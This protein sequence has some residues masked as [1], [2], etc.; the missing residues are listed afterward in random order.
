[1]SVTRTLLRGV[2]SVWSV[3]CVAGLST[4][5]EP[6]WKAGT[7][8]AVITPKKALWMAGYG[9]RTEPAEG[10]LHDLWIRVLALEDAEGQRGIVLSSDTLGIPKA[11]YDEV[12]LQVQDRYQL[13]RSQVMLHA[14]HT[15]CGPVI[16][17]A[18]LDIYPVNEQ[19]LGDI[20]D[21][22]KWLTAEI[23]STIGEA[24]KD[25]Q[26]VTISRG[27]GSADFAVNRRTN[28]EPD[29]PTL[30][31]Q[32]LLMGPVDHTVPVLA[33]YGM[34]DKLKAVVFT[35]ACHNTTLSFQKW[36]GD[37]AG[38]AQYELE[39]KHP[40]ATALFCMG[41]GADQNPLPRRTIE[42][43]E[44]YGKKL[45]TAVESV[46]SAPRFA[47]RP[48][49]ESRHAFVKLKMDPFPEVSKLE[50]MAAEPVSYTQRWASR[51]LKL[52]QKGV[53]TSQE[54]DYP[55]LVWR[56]GGDQLWITLGGEV[57]VDYA[58]RLKGEFGD[59]TWVSAYTNDVMAYIPS[60][61]VLLEGGYEGQSS[62]MVYGMPTER[63]APTVEERIDQGVA[64]LVKSL[65]SLP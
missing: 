27:I 63:W 22:F 48:K 58:L 31:E 52:A 49:L 6:G 47:V 41:C 12:C 51:L 11:M 26:P 36:C 25:L 45:A 50:K 28:R 21:Y 15:H 5:A 54:Y 42:L 53:P 34:D 32:N 65:P 43:C 60:K 37:Y 39:S 13:D 1:M 59:Q 2:V 33:V 16:G 7:A 30:R 55:I 56:L 38:F 20:H 61:R 14:S 35:Y 9:S 23:V 8:R 24:L 64:I 10:K 19:Q 57:V 62:M 44:Q 17:T 3:V 4:A 46:L 29:V 18:L 40:G